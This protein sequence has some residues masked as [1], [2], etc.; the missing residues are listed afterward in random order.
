MTMP[1]LKLGL[2]F[3]SFALLLLLGTELEAQ[4]HS[5]RLSVEADHRY[6]AGEEWFTGVTAQ[7]SLSDIPLHGRYVLEAVRAT[8]PRT[9]FVAG[10][11]VGEDKLHRWR[12]DALTSYYGHVAFLVTDDL[13]VGPLLRYDI[14]DAGSRVF[15]TLV[16]A[17]IADVYRQKLRMRWVLGATRFQYRWPEYNG[18]RFYDPV[19]GFLAENHMAQGGDVAGYTHVISLWIHQEGVTLR[20]APVLEFALNEWLTSGPLFEGSASGSNGGAGLFPRAEVG[21]FLRA[22]IQSR[23]FLQLTP[24]YP[25]LSYDN[26]QIDGVFLTGSVG[27]RL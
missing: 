11:R 1:D 21:L 3:L 12:G 5:Y 24:R 13:A 14:R 18:G 22:Y 8:V 7:Y 25:V 26:H 6:A 23:L 15:H 10:L 16:V 4:H 20:Y 17:A 19:W 27:V 2:T 9:E